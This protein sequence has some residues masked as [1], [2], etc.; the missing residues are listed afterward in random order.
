MLNNDYIIHQSILKLHQD[1]MA[2]QGHFVRILVS[3]LTT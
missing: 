1:M 3:K 2:H